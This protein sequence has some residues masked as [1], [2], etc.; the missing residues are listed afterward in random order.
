MGRHRPGV[1]GG[2]RPHP[3]L[4]RRDQRA[5]RHGPVRDVR[6]VDRPGARAPVLARP[7]APDRRLVRAPQ[8]ALRHA[9]QRERARR[10]RH[11]G[12]RQLPGHAAEQAVGPHREPAVHAVGPDGE[13]AAGAE[14]AREV[15]GLRPQHELRALPD[16]PDQL[17]I[18]LPPGV[19]RVHRPGPAS[20]AGQG[21]RDPAVRHRGG[22]VHGPQRTRDDRRGAGHHQR[23][24]QG[25]EPVQEEGVLPGRARGESPRPT[26]NARA[27][28]RSPTRSSATTTSS[29]RWCW[30]RRTRFPPTPRC[31]SRRVRARI[32]WSRRCRCCGT[33]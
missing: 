11:P 12:G 2:R 4:G 7:M 21:V 27:T 22:R 18:Q 32:C 14:G 26:A 1:R 10:P 16:A 15:R 29:T 30:H 28:A 13:A 3:R 33:T 19:H 31:S 25:A 23:A 24:H 9:G 5:A 17:R 8:R 6:V 20:G